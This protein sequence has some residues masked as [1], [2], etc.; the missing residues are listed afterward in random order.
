[1][2]LSITF[3]ITIIIVIVLCLTIVIAKNV[4]DDKIFRNDEKQVNKD[5]L[6][7]IGTNLGSVAVKQP[8]L[9]KKWLH[10]YGA[11]KIILG[12]DVKDQ[13]ISVSGWKEESKQEYE[14]LLVFCKLLEERA[15]PLKGRADRLFRLGQEVE[16]FIALIK[17]KG[18]N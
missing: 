3:S 5:D 17:G 4:I 7:D 14:S 9:F 8:E 2:K 16:L 6:E 18:K 1:M 15:E 10:Q 12:A 11:E 13:R